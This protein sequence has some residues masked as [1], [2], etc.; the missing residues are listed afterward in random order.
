MWNISMAPESPLFLLSSQCPP[1]VVTVPIAV[2][3]VSFVCSW[4]SYTWNQIACGVVCHKVGFE[5]RPC[6]CAPTS[7]DM[8]RFLIAK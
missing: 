7:P 5:I 3:V 8:H 1:S 6:C 4:T 2:I